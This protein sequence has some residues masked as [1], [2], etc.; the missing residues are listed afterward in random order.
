MV[1]AN[2]CGSFH[3]IQMLYVHI[4]TE[5]SYLL[6]YLPFSMMKK[7]FPKLLSFDDLAYMVQAM[8]VHQE[9]FKMLA[10]FVVEYPRL[11]VGSCLLPNLIRLYQ[12]LHQEMA[13]SVTKETATKITLANIKKQLAEKAPEMSKEFIELHDSVIGMCF[14]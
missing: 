6:F 5:Y 3:L 8:D 4:L 14:V 12:W 11:H 10:Q 7:Q 9:Q 13:H 1:Y 2:A